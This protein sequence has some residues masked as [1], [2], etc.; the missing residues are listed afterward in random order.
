MMKEVKITVIISYRIY[1]INVKCDIE[2]IKCG[3]GEER[4]CVGVDRS[5]SGLGAGSD[6]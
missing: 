1:K 5:Q 3:G 2:N 4:V 6:R